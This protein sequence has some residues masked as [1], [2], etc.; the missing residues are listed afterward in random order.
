M[1]SVFAV[2]AAI[3]RAINHLAHPAWTDSLAMFLSGLGTFGFVWILLG[4]FLFIREEKKDHWFFVPLLTV[5]LTA[6][7]G[8]E[9][10]LKPFFGRLR[11]SADV[12]AIVIGN[13]LETYSFPSAHA[14]IA[15]AC[16]VI[17]SAKEK[18]WSFWF[19]LLATLIALSRVYLGVHY[20]SDIVAGSILGF[21]FGYGSMWIS[22]II[23]SSKRFL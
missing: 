8:T 6:W 21:V 12:G 11:P 7:W 17:L 22:R 14:V 16:A 4:F 5:F 19:Y 3:F 23:G 20:P 9:Y 1:E 2:D 15:F 10:I 18:R 13:Y